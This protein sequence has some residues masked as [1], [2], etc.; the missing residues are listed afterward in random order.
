[1][2]RMKF[3]VV[4]DVAFLGGLKLHLAFE[5][6]TEG[7]IELLDLKDAPGLLGETAQPEMFHR[8]FVDRDAGTLAWPNGLDLDPLV[9][10]S[11]VSGRSIEDLI[12]GLKVD[13]PES[14]RA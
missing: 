8:V 13:K 4:R 7:D 9:L 1:M 10:Y 5:D 2:K 14:A 3:P 11:D 6:G 12:Q